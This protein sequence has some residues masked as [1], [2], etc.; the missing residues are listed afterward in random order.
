MGDLL[1][2][3]AVCQ[4]ADFRPRYH[5]RIGASSE[6]KNTSSG[7]FLNFG[8]LAPATWSS[9]STALMQPRSLEAKIQSYGS[10]VKMLRSSMAGSHNFPIPAQYSSWPEEQRA[11]AETAALSDMGQ[12]MH[13]VFFKGPDVLRL[14]ADH[15]VNSFANFRKNNAKQLVLCNEDGFVIGDSVVVAL[16]DDEFEVLG[17]PVNANWLQFRAE[18]GKYKV[19]FDVDPMAPYNTKERRFFRYQ[20]QGPRALQIVE[21][22]AGG[23]LPAIKFFHVGEFKI[24]GVAVRALGHTMTR[25]A[26]FEIFGPRADGPKVLMALRE[27]GR[28]FGMREN[29]AI[30]LPTGI[31][32][33][34]LGLQVPAIYSGEKMRPFREWVSEY[35]F[36]GFASLGG[37]YASENID[38]YYTTPWDIGYGHLVK[39]DHDYVGKAALQKLAAQPPPRQK[40]FLRWDEQDVARVL[41]SSLFGKE[42]RTKMLGVPYSTYATFPNDQVLIGDKMVG[43]SVISVYTVNVGSWFSMAVVDTQHAIDGQRVDILWGDADTS[44]RP[45]ATEKHVLTKIGATVSIKALV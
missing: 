10:A 32:G 22:A 11:W 23:S 8:T 37:S 31:E 43:I 45:L 17:T 25:Q 29:G 2:P 9:E 20:I 39:F 12:H 6:Q 35:G 1:V 7:I 30:S 18:Q 44:L 27:A 24:A 26:G 13:S 41:A 33:G 14:F 42:N 40:V 36:E 21:K 3:A 5:I 19:E 15:G 28:E 38:D 16:E 34:W 4:S